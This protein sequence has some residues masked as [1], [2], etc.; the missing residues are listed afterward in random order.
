MPII[1]KC[2]ACQGFFEETNYL[3]G[4]TFGGRLWTDGSMMARGLPS[5]DWLVK[6]PHCEVYLWIDEQENLG[7]YPDDFYPDD[8]DPDDIE[9]GTF[10][11]DPDDFDPELKNAKHYEVPSTEEILSVLEKVQL[12]ENKERYLR[13]RFWWLENTMRRYLFADRMGDEREPLSERESENIKRLFGLL[14][15]SGEEDRLMMAEIKRELGEFEEAEDLLE[16]PFPKR[17]TYA[18]ST[19]KD[20]I[21]KHDPFVAPIIVPPDA[22]IE[23]DDEDDDVETIYYVDEVAEMLKRELGL[24]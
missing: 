13:V 22:E 12:P 15:R 24:W 21:D 19:M 17:L 6:C 9:N 4:N 18:V 16:G 10:I 2:S 7:E 11:L 23:W 20:L 5:G 1:R 8:I 14:D 3:S